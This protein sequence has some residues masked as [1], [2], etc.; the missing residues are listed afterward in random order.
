MSP[1]GGAPTVVWLSMRGEGHSTD[2]W[3]VAGERYQLTTWM[4]VMTAYGFDEQ[5]VYLSD[6][7]TSVWRIYSWEEFVAMWGVMDGMALSIMP[8]RRVEGRIAL[9]FESVRRVGCGYCS[10]INRPSYRRSYTA[11]IIGT[12]ATE[13]WGTHAPAPSWEPGTGSRSLDPRRSIRSSSIR[14]MPRRNPVRRSR[15]LACRPTPVGNVGGPT[16]SAILLSGTW[17]SWARSWHGA[18]F[19]RASGP[20]IQ[21]IP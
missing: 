8:S 19:K 5:G 14:M 13:R 21:P 6:P 15:Y 2:R 16:P 4:H 11:A 17:P 10:S 7:G 1:A 3:D 18:M 20:G 9:D 12:R